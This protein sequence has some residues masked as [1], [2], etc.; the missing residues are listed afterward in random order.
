MGLFSG[1]ESES[2]EVILSARD[3]GLT[4]TLRGADSQI[5]ATAER[6]KRLG[7]AFLIFEGLRKSID[8]VKD[9][10]KAAA[11]QQADL[12]QVNVALKDNGQNVRAWSAS[13]IDALKKRAAASGFALSDETNSFVKLEGATKNNAEALKILGVAQDVSRARHVSLTA[14]SLALAKGVEGSTTSLARYGIIVPKVTT[15]EDQLKAK[16]NE[17]TAAHVKQTAALK[18]QYAAAM[19]AAKAQD[20]QATSA[21]VAAAAAGENAGASEA[22]AKSLSGQADRTKVSI[23]ELEATIGRKL[24]PTERAAL[25]QVSSWVDELQHSNR[26][27]QDATQFAHGLGVAWDD[28][29]SVL[30]T[31]G[32]PLLEIANDTSKV[33]QAA[34]GIGTILAF[35]AAWYTASKGISLGAT[36]LEG[37]TRFAT[38]ARA[39]LAT[40]GAA[41]VAGRAPLAV[42]G[43]EAFVSSLGLASAGRGAATAESD[44]AGIAGAAEKAGPSLSGFGAGLAGAFSGVGAATVAV[45]LLAGG[46]YYLSTQE[47]DAERSAKRTASAFDLLASSAQKFNSAGQNLQ[48][49]RINTSSDKLARQQASLAVSQAKQTLADPALNK[50]ALQHRQNVLSLAQAYNEWRIANHAVAGDLTLT[51]NDVKAQG[52]AANG[53]QVAISKLAHSL[54]SQANAAK[55]GVDPLHTLAGAHGGV[56]SSVTAEQRAVDKAAASLAAFTS[57]TT[58]AAASHEKSNPAIA[59]ATTLLGQFAQAQQRVP[60]KAEITFILQHA[61]ASDDLKTITTKV[62]D[63]DGKKV[64]GELQLAGVPRIVGDIGN[65]RQLLQGLTNTPWVIPISYSTSGNPPKNPNSGNSS[66]PLPPGHTPRSGM[67]IAGAY[68]RDDTPVWVTGSEAILNPTQIGMVD[69]GWSVA[70]ALAA[71]GA[72]TL[73][74]GGSY[75]G[76]GGN[77]VTTFGASADAAL[78]KGGTAKKKAA[79]TH[80]GHGKSGQTEEQKAEAAFAANATSFTNSLGG[81]LAS[82]AADQLNATKKAPLT[83]DLKQLISKYASRANQLTGLRADKRFKGF[84]GAV[85]AINSELAQDYGTVGGY[86]GDLQTLLAPGAAAPGSVAY[87]KKFGGLQLAFHADQTAAARPIPPNLSASARKKAAAAIAAAKKAVPGDRKRMISAVQNR[88]AELTKLR[89]RPPR[90]MLGAI[91]D[92]LDADQQTLAGLYGDQATDDTQAATDASANTFDNTAF[93]QSLNAAQALVARDNAIPDYASSLAGDQAALGSLVTGRVGDIQ[94]LLAGGGINA[95]TADAATQE[96][97]SDYGIL[98]GLLPGNTTNA[99]SADDQAII[100]QLQ[101]Q[102][103]IQTRSAGLSNAALSVF[104]GSGDIGSGGYR[105][106]YASA[107]GSGPAINIYTLHPSDPATLAA[108][109]DASNAG[110]S[111]QQ[112]IPSGRTTVNL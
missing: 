106:A 75:A 96:L 63:F 110:N 84:P 53:T 39:A 92:E 2:F 7:E 41:S 36:A 26:V 87:T 47:S 67:Y 17:L 72:P 86:R 78:A 37:V 94:R 80:A 105:N 4:S 64:Q 99:P 103:A 33:V 19:A 28:T 69:A 54:T 108:I 38:P 15:V 76:G 12:A 31:V 3:A 18:D 100:A 40:E 14:V 111:L 59:H 21:K 24:I 107:Q 101:Q 27:Q 52:D 48:G 50:D 89:K 6:V 77:P 44:I 5:D 61:K 85:A 8:L 55:E 57:A 10:G 20:K 79:A 43:G 9:F 56:A 29:V 83:R 22:Y 23:D 104:G 46:L 13:T 95:A 88:I 11:D 45:G 68:G 16:K 70:G 102:L 109:A 58:S 73:V 82:Y 81:L 112:S 71:T 74:R 91:L 97:T 65:V 90:G 25:Q 93:T 35:G 62:K 1:G 51:K 49:D 98:Q 60:S 66:S 32:P 30:R 34:G 42:G